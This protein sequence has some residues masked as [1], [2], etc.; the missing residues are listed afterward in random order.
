[1]DEAWRLQHLLTAAYWLGGPIVLAMLALV[2]HR[3][4]DEQALRTLM[5]SAGH[6]F[7]AGSVIAWVAHWS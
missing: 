3:I 7:S 2:A 6:A 5:V 4:L 1:V